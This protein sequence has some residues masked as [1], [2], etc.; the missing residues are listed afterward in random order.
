M[1][2]DRLDLNYQVNHVVRSCY[3]QIRNI[4]KIRKYLTVNA[5]KILVH[6]LV[7]STI[8]YCNSLY[9][10]LQK[11]SINKLQKLQNWAARI[12]IGKNIFDHITPILKLLHWLP[13]RKWIEFKVCVIVFKVLSGT[14]P[15][16]ISDRL[17][18]Y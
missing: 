16:Y 17:T 4:T 9:L 6:S 18:G 5:T 12:I 11:S 3:T 1:V 8:D 14:S 2:D 13:V 10:V 7:I 15:K